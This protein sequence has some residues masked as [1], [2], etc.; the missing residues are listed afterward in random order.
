MGA[1][2]RARQASDA[3]IALA[4]GSGKPGRLGRLDGRPDGRLG[5]PT[6]GKDGKSGTSGVRDGPG[7]SGDENVGPGDWSGSSGD[8]GDGLGGEVVGTVLPGKVGV[9][10]LKD[11]KGG[12]G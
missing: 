12:S 10:M 2:S 1:G 3:V 11:G 6:L 7:G 5:K 8:E 4:R 9:G